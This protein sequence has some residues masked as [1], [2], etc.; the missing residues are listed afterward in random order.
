MGCRKC[1]QH[2][3]KPARCGGCIAFIYL[4]VAC[5]RGCNV[6]LNTAHCIWSKPILKNVESRT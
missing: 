1:E 3:P 6:V 4:G 5:L 2:A